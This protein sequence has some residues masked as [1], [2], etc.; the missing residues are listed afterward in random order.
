ML[1][2]A[3]LASFCCPLQRKT[4]H[5][6]VMLK[7]LVP[8]KIFTTAMQNFG[9]HIGD[10]RQCK[11]NTAQYIPYAIETNFAKKTYIAALFLKGTVLQKSW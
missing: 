2:L 9:N 10:K 5:E 3:R 11:Y 4:I 1:Q 8:G 6:I 7:K